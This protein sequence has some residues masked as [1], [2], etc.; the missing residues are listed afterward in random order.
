MMEM[1][2]IWKCI[3]PYSAEVR[4]RRSIELSTNLTLVKFQLRIVKF[5]TLRRMA[6]ISEELNSVSLI[7]KSL[8]DMEIERLW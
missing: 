6:K 3:A 2:C 5:V 1:S 7:V 8:I 4:S